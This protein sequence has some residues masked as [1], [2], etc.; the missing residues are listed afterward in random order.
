MKWSSYFFS[1]MTTSWTSGETMQDTT[2][3]ISS[4]SIL[5]LRRRRPSPNL[6][7]C[8]NVT[9]LFPTAS[10]LLKVH[11]I[12]SQNFLRQIMTQSSQPSDIHSPLLP[13]PLP[14]MT[15]HTHT[16]TKLISFNAWWLCPFLNTTHLFLTI[17]PFPFYWIFPWYTCQTSNL[18]INL[19]K[20]VSICRRGTSP[21]S[22]LWIYRL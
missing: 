5:F 6:Q 7:H 12:F 14:T 19:V 10:L 18:L 16:H 3:L 21:L 17:I 4:L 20:F 22:D 11:C 2:C 9:T 15:Q 13:F 8:F 1:S